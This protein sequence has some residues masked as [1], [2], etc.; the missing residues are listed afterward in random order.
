MSSLPRILAA[1]FLALLVAGGA[2][3]QE[4]AAAARREPWPKE[5]VD[6]V[7]LLA[8][9][10]GG[11]VKPLHTLASFRMLAINGKRSLEVALAGGGQERLGP[12]EWLLDC[13]FFREQAARYA[14]IVVEDVEVLDHL[15]LPHAGKKKRDRYSYEELQPGFSV[16]MDK[17]DQYLRISEEARTPVQNHVIRLAQSVLQTSALLGFMEFA[18]LRF[19]LAE[20]GVLR[21]RFPGA[22]SVAVS[23]VLG[24]CP[25]L[26]E[27]YHA[28]VESGA[29]AGAEARQLDGVFAFL[30]LGASRWRAIALVPPPAGE[31][32][33]LSPADLAA[34][35]AAGGA[36]M[37]SLLEPLARLERLF[38]LRADPAAFAKELRALAADLRARAQARAEYEGIELEVFYNRADLFFWAQWLFVLG[39]LFAALTWLTPRSRVLYQ[40]ARWW[41]VLPV[42]F[43]CAGIAL[44]CV[45]RGRPPVTTLYETILFVAACSAAIALVIEFLNRRRVALIISSVVGALGLFLAGWFL[46]ERAQDTMPT[47][48]A[49]LDTNFWL[50]THVTTITIGYAAGLLAAALAHVYVGGKLLG[51]RRADPEFYGAIAR[52]VYGSVAFVLVFSI[53]GTILGGIWANESW[54]RFW[55]WDPKENGALMIVLASLII[56]HARLGKHLQDFGVCLAAIALGTVVA[57][58]WFHVN[59]LR[60]GLHTYGFD[61]SLH[62]LVW[63][64]YWVEWIV[65][66]LGCVAWLRERQKAAPGC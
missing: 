57:F 15:G 21:E 28:L 2:A 35:A 42:V 11:R 52:M 47:L 54:G 58:S 36:D 29:G 33:W 65:L 59:L 41:L 60:V 14:F 12:V 44:R 4:S 51:L 37:A 55:G 26:L 25:D 56:L 32:V 1:C 7:A 3:A 10:E 45:L 13:L 23:Q 5:V 66:G 6:L 16:L 8:V 43:A 39:F 20:F 40:A 64:F 63:R 31:E 38:D 27:Q 30:N 17:L 53:I 61:E 9:Q 22:E 46:E 24:A 62:T 49:V 50:S 19:R 48:L 34:R 18:E